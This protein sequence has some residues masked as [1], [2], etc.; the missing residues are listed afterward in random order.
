MNVYP[1]GDEAANLSH[2]T[3][4]MQTLFPALQKAWQLLPD[5]DDKHERFLEH[6][7]FVTEHS[8]QILHDIDRK[9]KK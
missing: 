3:E 8:A 2:Y 7:Q 6:I 4:M 1:T 9:K 5:S